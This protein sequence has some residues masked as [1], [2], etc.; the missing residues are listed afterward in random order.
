[1][2]RKLIEWSLHNPL[3]VLLF[4]AAL[5]GVGLYSFLNVNVEAYPDPA[6]AII[7]VIAQWPG[8]SA[9]DVERKVTIPLEVQLAGMPGLKYT[10]SKSLAG[11]SHLRNQFDYG[12]DF[13]AARQEVFNRLNSVQGLPAGVSPQISP[14]T[15]TGELV[16]YVLSNPRDVLGREQYNLNDLKALE[17]VTLEREFKRIPGVIDVTSFGGT[18]KRYEIQPDPERLQRYGITLAQL[19][20]AL[21][22]SN[23]N[24]GGDNLSQGATAMNVRGLGLFG[25]GQDPAQQ[26][27]GTEVREFEAL[28]AAN[29]KLSDSLRVRL[30]TSLQGAIV[31]PPLSANEKA[32]LKNVRK[33][34]DGRSANKA[35]PFLRAAEAD[36]L[37]EIRRTVVASVNNVP[38]RIE[39]LVDGGP[40]RSAADDPGSRGVV[41][42]YQ[43]RL[44]KV[45]RSIRTDKGWK[46][47][48][49]VVMGIVLMRKNE[50]SLPTLN[51]LNAKL[52]DLNDHPGRLLPGV[53]LERIYDL[54][55]LIHVT[56]ETVQ[57]NLILGMV[58]VTVILFMFLS[59]VRSALI[60]AIN[61]PLALLFAFSV[62]FLRGKSANLLSI[63]AVDFGIIVDSSVIMVENIY[64]H[65][66][67]GEHADLSLRERILR[68][69]SEVQRALLFSTLI[70]VCAFLPLFTMSGPEGQIFGPMAD[71][72]AFALGGALLLALTLAPVLCLLLFKHLK[73]AP[74]NFLVRWLKRRYLWQLNLCLKYRWATL[75][76][77]GGLVVFTLCLL[78]RLGHEFMP[79][80]EE[81]NLWI[82][83]TFPVNIS[84]HEASE[85]VRIARSVIQEEFPEVEL[86]VSQVGR[87]DDGTDP[88]GYYNTEFYIPLKPEKEWPKVKPQ[89]GWLSRFRGMRRRTKKEVIEDIKAALDRNLIGVDWNFSQYVRDNVMESLSGVKGDNSVKIIGPD[90]DR[91]EKLAEKVKAEMVSI[92]GIKEVGVFHVL[93]QPNLDLPVDRDKCMRWGIGIGDV[94]AVIQTAVGGRAVTQMV[95]GEKSF[96]VTLRWPVPLRNNVSAILNIPVDVTNNLVTASF[97]NSRNQT[98]LTGGSVG[99]SATGSANTGASNTGSMFGA[100]FNDPTTTPRRRLGDLITP[101]DAKGQQSPEGSF[102][103]PGASTIYRE[104]G[105]RL[106]AIKF[107]VRDRDLA[108]AVKEAQEKTA[109]L[110]QAPYRAEWSGEF[111]EM[112]A[113]ERKLLWII[114]LSLMLIF[115]LLYLA[116]HSFLDALAVLSNVLALSM[117]GIWALLLTDTHFSISAA[118]GFISL[119]G[120]AIMDGLLLISYFNQLRAEG[121][122]LHEAIMQ[123]AAKR[124]RPV[125]MTALTA[126]FGLVPAALSTRI[127]AQTQRPLAIVVVGGMITTLLLTRYLMP[128]LYSFYG[129]RTPPEGAGGMAH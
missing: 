18:V 10:R 25:Q 2:V 83:G 1:M 125:M 74:D 120:V 63:G 123:G 65:L 31:E 23:A 86:I 93:G 128:V 87:P 121:L 37:R 96:D 11:L 117:G 8:A 62:L 122:P 34:A 91:L 80:L 113:A 9:E 24:I 64:R 102:V 33:A 101:L 29:S 104:Q 26:V 77:M 112:E 81:G 40:L 97:V 58:L 49:D 3:I 106:I 127:G 88:T 39:E 5:I 22:N 110:F 53:Q 20:N 118:V 21:G 45:A 78:P 42:S 57:E 99:V 73:P 67:A 109:R 100:S 119:F 4:V 115:I 70:M 15:P 79:E 59:N 72:Y 28:L 129:Q 95:E 108:G 69:S 90:L 7:E 17:D 76:V 36:R 43:T 6:P 55:H 52:D 38:V 85:K 27:L 105:K 126:I 14:E 75:V 60:V 50:H 54:S 116:F 103:R 30:R 12:V 35:A 13:F 48:P 84:L 98:T 89:E 124:V 71:T 51:K 111:E 114:P 82:R 44:G 61:V 47:E 56:T 32:H 66:S 46:D 68:A 107:S 94:L 92:R 41:I 19:S 16:R